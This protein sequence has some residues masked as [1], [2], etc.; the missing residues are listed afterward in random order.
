MNQKVLLWE[1]D[2]APFPLKCPAEFLLSHH[3]EPGNPFADLDTDILQVRYW[4]SLVLYILFLFV[5]L[6]L[7]IRT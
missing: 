2:V 4:I 3:Y 6:L 7:V 5:L 1:E